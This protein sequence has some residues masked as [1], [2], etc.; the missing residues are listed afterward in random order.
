MHTV[1]AGDPPMRLAGA[2]VAAVCTAA[3]CGGGTTSAAAVAPPAQDA[4]TSTP[5]AGSAPD[6]GVTPPDAGP[7]DAGPDAGIDG[8]AT[9]C[10]GL[11]STD[12]GA[13]VVVN[14]DV[15][16]PSEICS[17]AQPD[18]GGTV[19]LRIATYDASGIH[20]AA[21][22]FYGASDGARLRLQEWASGLGPVS[23]LAQPDGF[24]GIEFTGDARE[25]DLHN[26][27][28][29]GKEVSISHTLARE[30]E[31]VAV[32]DPSGGTVA[33]AVTRESAA[34]TLEFQRFDAQGSLSAN[35][36]VAS[37]EPDTQVSWVAGVSTGGDTLVV[38]AFADRPCRAVWLDRAG[39]AVSAGF[40]PGTCRIHRFYPL[41]DGGLA[42][43]TSSLDASHSIANVVGPR[44]TAFIAAPDWLDGRN[45]REFFILPGLKGYALREQGAGER[46]RLFL[47]GGES[48]GELAAPTL[49]RGP[50]QIG[51]DG[52]LIEQDLTGA[53]CTFRWHPQLFE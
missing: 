7:P 6:G 2:L 34:S 40:A 17:A 32:A 19:P 52:T 4:G 12:A 45:L 3:G 23:L 21:W 38:F 26:I 24:T 47:P 20:R 44:G 42:V 39:K 1:Q 28:G 8:G 46:F 9:G 36:A 11:V 53:G 5:D 33:F 10:A 25:I 49:E 41:L 16:D 50:V 22:A 30:A 31:G 43:E 51:R 15:G 37:A 13:P 27:A 18:E 14:L 35:G 29:D 48:C